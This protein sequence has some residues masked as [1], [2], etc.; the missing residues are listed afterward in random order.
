MSLPPPP[1]TGRGKEIVDL[2]STEQKRRGKDSASGS[3]ASVA[4]S[5]SQVASA[6]SDFGS[7]LPQVKQLLF[8]E[9]ECHLKKMGSSQVVDLGMGHL[10]QVKCRGE[11][12]WCWEDRRGR[13]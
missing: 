3:E 12:Y 9:D 4:L 5:F 2:S 8:L 1:L 6:Y 7:L 13:R 10:F 11:R